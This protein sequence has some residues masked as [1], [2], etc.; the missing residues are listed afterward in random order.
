[1]PLWVKKLDCLLYETIE[2]KKYNEKELIINY[3]ELKNYDNFKIIN[4]G[5]IG[6]IFLIE[7]NNK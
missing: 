1:M 5:S 4:S 3:P 6:S 2:K 7:K